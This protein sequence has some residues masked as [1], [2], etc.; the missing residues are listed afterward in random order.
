VQ[1]GTPSYKINNGT[2]TQLAS[3]YSYTTNDVIMIAVD[4]D[5]GKFWYGKNGAW[6]ESGDPA[7]GTNALYTNLTDTIIPMFGQNTSGNSCAVNFGQRPFAYTAPSGFKALVTTNLPEPTIAAGNE[8][9]DATTYTGNGTTNVITNS[10]SMQPDFVWMKARSYAPNHALVDVLRGTSWQLQ[11]STTNAESQNSAGKGLQSF[12]SNGFTLG[13]ES[14]AIGGTNRNGDTYIAW[15]W[16]ANGAGSTNTAG[17]IT[18]TVSV[19]TTSGF[20]I[21]T[22]AGNS[23]AAATVGHGLGVTP[24]LVIVKNR[25]NSG[26][27]WAVRHVSLTATQNLALQTTDAA[28]TVS[29]ATSNGG[30]G[31][32]SSTTF[33]FISGTVG[34]LN[35]NATSNNYVAYCFA[36]VA[37]YSAFGSFTGNQSTDGPFVYLGFRPRWVLIKASSA[38]TDWWIWDTARN[39]YNVMNAVLYPD[40]SNAEYSDS[41]TFLMD[42]LSNGF[43]YRTSNSTVNGSGTTY[44]YAAFAENP[45][46]YSLAR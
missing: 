7:S 33:T 36:P 1:L 21:V 22:Y 40:L 5:A 26:H 8:Y 17:T 42:A 29:S 16:K 23:T 25:T 38:V 15:Q 34:L 31:T 30:I 27:S 2:F 44:I 43:K 32:L 3:N 20:S 12:N 45:F 9:F 28:Y 6:I 11:S 24:S 10:G 41:S 46:A 37:G 35:V 13:E 14:D 4:V 19:N 18:S 39:T